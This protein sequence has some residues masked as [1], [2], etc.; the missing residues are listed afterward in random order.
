MNKQFLSALVL[1]ATSC[2]H[3]PA[4]PESA[5][6]VAAAELAF[7]RAAQTRTVNEAFLAV[8]A[9]DAMLFRPGP[10]NGPEYHAEHPIPADALLRWAP[11]YA[12]T[13]AD[14]SL[15]FTTGPYEAGTRGQPPRSTGHFLSVWRNT[16]GTWRLVFDGG[17]P[18]PIELSVD[19]AAGSVRERHNTQRFAAD[20]VSLLEAERAHAQAGFT[21]LRAIVAGSGD[22]GYVYGTTGTSDRPR[23][24]A[25]IYRRG[26]GGQWQVIIDTLDP[27]VR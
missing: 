26:P 22:L 14:G 23:G 25:R 27:H 9:P 4:R 24:Y 13:S 7:A 11:S 1:L 15:G 21:P 20:T 10:V 5:S 2:A 8:L 16:A 6:S 18:G 17:T 19:S 3:A 12:E